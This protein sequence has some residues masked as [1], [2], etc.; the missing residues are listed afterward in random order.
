MTSQKGCGM[1]IWASRKDIRGSVRRLNSGM[2]CLLVAYVSMVSYLNRLFFMPIHW[3]SQS[4]GNFGFSGVFCLLASRRTASDQT[5]TDCTEGTGPL[6]STWYSWYLHL[7]CRRSGR[8]QYGEWIFGTIS[9]AF[10][11]AQEAFGAKA[12]WQMAVSL[13]SNISD[14]YG[15]ICVS[16]QSIIDQLI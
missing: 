4:M 16:A 3:G 12:V 11:I 7:L 14:Q 8:R 10:W 5:C 15:V 13:R 2:Y 1:T 9:L 6:L